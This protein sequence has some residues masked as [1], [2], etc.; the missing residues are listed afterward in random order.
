MDLAWCWSR[1]QLMFYRIIHEVCKCWETLIKR[2][3]YAEKLNIFV[4]PSSKRLSIQAW[5]FH[6]DLLYAGKSKSKGKLLHHRNEK[7]LIRVYVNCNILK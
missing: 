3:D 6:L 7:E 2:K 4:P 1:N 5:N